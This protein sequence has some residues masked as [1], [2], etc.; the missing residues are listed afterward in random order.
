MQAPGVASGEGRCHKGKR[1]AS[2]LA[3]NMDH[4]R[5]SACLIVHA[6]NSLWLLSHKHCIAAVLHWYDYAGLA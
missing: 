6:Y 2:T 1:P 4:V 5:M 3:S